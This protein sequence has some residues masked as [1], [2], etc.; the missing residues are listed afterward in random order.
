MKPNTYPLRRVCRTMNPNINPFRRG[1]SHYESKHIPDAYQH[2]RFSP[3]K[4]A[5]IASKL[6]DLLRSLSVCCPFVVRLLSDCCPFINRTTNGQRADNN[7]TTTEV[8]TVQKRHFC[9][10]L[11]SLWRICKSAATEISRSR[12]R[13]AVQSLG[14]VPLSGSRRE[15]R[16]T[17]RLLCRLRSR[18]LLGC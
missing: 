17:R 1:V 14:I 3:E 16:R 9:R 12:N 13:L 10:A 8:D 5:F 11:P 7:R 6:Q 15:R 18:R 2:P 4:Q